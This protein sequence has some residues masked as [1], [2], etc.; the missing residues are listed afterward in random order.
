MEPSPALCLGASVYPSRA[1]RREPPL[2]PLPQTGRVAR[3]VPAGV[4]VEV[5]EDI[6]PFRRV[7]GQPLGPVIQPRIR[8]TTAVL[9]RAFMEP[10]VDKRTDDHPL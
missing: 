1:S 4:V 9:F 10:H 5:G 3:S 2:Q 6:E 8:V 7:F